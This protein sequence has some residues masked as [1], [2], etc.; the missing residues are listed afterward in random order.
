MARVMFTALMA[1]IKGRIGGTVF[2][3][4]T[5]GYI[6]KEFDAIKE[7]AKLTKADAGRPFNPFD[8]TAY[9]AGR[10]RLLSDSDRATWNAGAVNY[11]AVTPFGISYTPSGYQVFMTLNTQIYN[12]TGAIVSECPL[13]ESIAALDECTIVQ[14]SLTS[15]TLDFD[16][17]SNPGFA[18][19]IEATRRMSLGRQPRKGDFKILAEIQGDETW[20]YQIYSAY[21]A[22]YGPIQAGGRIWFRF[23]L[24]SYTSGQKGVAQ[25]QYLNVT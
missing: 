14:A 13:P 2:Q 1:G 24:L 15:I 22:I 11:P 10:W 21:S 4:G 18:I 9:V 8:V 6:A 5:G 20:P 7:S 12:L 17:F 19:R 23:T 25:T 16:T 3:G